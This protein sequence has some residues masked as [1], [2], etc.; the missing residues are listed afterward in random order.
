MSMSAISIGVSGMQ[1]AAAQLQASA[2]N[3]ANMATTGAVPV[4][5][6]S[7]GGTVYQPVSVNQYVA[8]GGDSNGVAYSIS[9]NADGYFQTYDP[10]SPDANG[11]GMIAVPNVDI[12]TQMVNSMR[13]S[14]DYAASAKIVQVA[15]D[16]EKT[17]IDMIA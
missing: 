14:A 5:S 10:T 12:A 7:T 9:R 11:D 13:A 17:A 15:D 4:A 3:I 1:A 16:M 6:G 2:S 8:P